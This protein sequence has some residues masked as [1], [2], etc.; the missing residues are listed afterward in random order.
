MKEMN[1]TAADMTMQRYVFSE[2][3]GLNYCLSSKPPIPDNGGLHKKMVSKREMNVNEWERPLRGLFYGQWIFKAY[4][5]KGSSMKYWNIIHF[6]RV[7][8]FCYF[9]W[10]PLKTSV[11]F[12]CTKTRNSLMHDHFSLSLSL[13]IWINVQFWSSFFL[14]TKANAQ[15][16]DIFTYQCTFGK[17]VWCIMAT[18]WICLSQSLTLNQLRQHKEHKFHDMNLVILLELKL[19]RAH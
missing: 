16:S 3:R 10:G 7:T 13:T 6:S 2:Q 1:Y 4:P 14:K 12:F 15:C 8:T 9:P 19:K 11:K 18:G 5:R 17:S